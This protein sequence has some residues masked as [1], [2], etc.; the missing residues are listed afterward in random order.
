MFGYIYLTYNRINGK[1]YIGKRKGK[2]D[3][4]YVG[5]G[6]YL[7]KAV[8]KYGIENFAVSVLDWAKDRDELNSK[9]IKWIE[10]YDATN[11]HMFY[12]IQYGGAG[13]GINIEAYPEEDRKRVVE[14]YRQAQIKRFKDPKEIAKV[15]HYGED[16]GMYNN[17][18]KLE[19]GKNGRAKPVLVFKNNKLIKEF[20]C[21]K[22]CLRYY[23]PK[24][25]RKFLMKQSLKLNIPI[26]D[27]TV[28]INQH[29]EELNISKDKFLNYQFVHKD[30]TEV[31][32]SIKKGLTP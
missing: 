8:K 29:T 6:T 3:P 5:S 11:C 18:Y 10:E 15:V 14:N 23:E 19:G 16:N 1:K 12:N 26:K 9:E 2:F 17:G 31:I 32:K 21:E 28:G 30:N 13:G 25:L 27:Y 24:G 20:D 4:R 7:K 22:D